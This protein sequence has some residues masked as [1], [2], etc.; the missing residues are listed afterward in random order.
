ME[1][2]YQGIYVALLVGL[3]VVAFKY[4]MDGGDDDDLAH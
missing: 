4:F 3:L 1:L 2:I